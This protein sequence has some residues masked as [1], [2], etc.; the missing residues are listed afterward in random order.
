MVNILVAKTETQKLVYLTK[1][2]S[3]QDLLVMRNIH[4]FTCPDCGN[5]LF[6]KVG[7]IK[8]PH[9]AHKSLSDCDSFSEPESPLHLQG[10]VLLHQFFQDKNFPIEL[11]KY[12]P[13]IR[14]RADLLVNCNTVIEF[15]C[16]PI[17]ASDVLRRT[18]AYTQCGL[19]ST[20]IFGIKEKPVSSIRIIKLMEYQKE[21]LINQELSKHLLLLNPEARQ[22]NYYSNLFHISGNR[23]VGKVMTLPVANQTFPFAAPKSLNRK[24]FETVC[25]VFETAKSSFIRSQLFAKNRYQNPFWLLCYK[26]GLN[27][28]NFPAAI[29]VPILGSECI[30]DH[31][32]IWQLKMIRASR[33]GKSIEELIS[34]GTIKLHKKGS[35]LQ[36]ETVLS[37]YALFLDKLEIK[38][39][40][41]K[42]QSELLYDIYCKSVRKLR[43]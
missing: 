5:I 8:I 17:S 34:S 38:N 25:S 37:D 43:K 6:L 14:Q 41:T 26:L 21:M 39:T 16:S 9:F 13:E 36:F 40:E 22:F 3:R 7:D 24:D 35:I 11:E 32:V 27:M 2:Y 19:K 18:A 12:L 15:Q 31:A 20:W 4:K 42:M 29:G 30:A 10:K 28:Q 1:S 23:W 33:L